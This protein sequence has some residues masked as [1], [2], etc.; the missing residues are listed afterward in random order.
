MAAQVARE[1]E[2]KQLLITHISPR[3]T[4]GNATEPDELLNE[5]RAIFPNTEMA[6]D[7]LTVEVPRL[8]S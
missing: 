5:A 4:T 8:G 3:Y 7:F 6:H 1:A 2:A